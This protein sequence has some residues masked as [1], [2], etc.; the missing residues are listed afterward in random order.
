MNY[1]WGK[2]GKSSAVA[3]LKVSQAAAPPAPC[4][5]CSASCHLQLKSTGAPIDEDKPYAEFWCVQ[6][7]PSEAL[8]DLTVC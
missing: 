8:F 6:G 5:L 1:D 4:A 2:L 7:K 3:Q